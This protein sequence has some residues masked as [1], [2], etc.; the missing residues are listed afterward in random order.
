MGLE[1]S[2]ED[3][4]HKPAPRKMFSQ[5]ILQT[6]PFMGAPK[7]LW[8]MKGSVSLLQHPV[9]KS[10]QAGCSGGREENNGSTQS[11]DNPA[12]FI[13]PSKKDQFISSKPPIKCAL[14]VCLVFFTDRSL[15][16]CHDIFH[17]YSGAVD[18]GHKVAIHC[19]ISGHAWQ[20]FGANGGGKKCLLAGA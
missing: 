14:M 12:P 2:L 11:R 7:V 5:G 18:W 19:L 8:E 9:S 1:E 15:C 10:S 6:G 13:Q 4:G 16:S 3:R 17:F 20:F